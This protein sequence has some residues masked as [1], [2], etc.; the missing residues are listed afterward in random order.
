VNV[1]MD[2]LIAE[3]VPHWGT[4]IADQ[5]LDQMRAARELRAAADARAEQLV[6]L[7]RSAGVVW[8]DR[9]AA[10]L[11]SMKDT[12]NARVG[13]PILAIRRTPHGTVSVVADNG[14]YVLFAFGFVDLDSPTPDFSVVVQPGRSAGWRTQM[15]YELDV[16]DAGALVSRGLEL[17]PEAFAQ[18]ACEAWLR[19]LPLN[20]R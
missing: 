16:D 5:M 7:V 13:R 14:P 6:A 10:E 15:P 9:L 18:F 12:F 3:S 11:T 17:G 1:V 4:D 2:S 19:A 20:G 8:V